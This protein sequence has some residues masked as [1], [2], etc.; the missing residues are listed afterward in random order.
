M[1][2]AKANQHNV[3]VHK[4]SIT[5]ADGESIGQFTSKL[6]DAGRNYI[7]SKLNLPKDSSVYP[8]E[9]F[10]KSIVFDV[11]QYGPN[12]KEGDRARFYAAAY[13][14]KDS[15][16]FEFSTLTEVERVTSYQAKQTATVMKASDKAP[17]W[18][19][20]AVAKAAFWSGVI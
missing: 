3:V 13:A 2:Q 10:S 19:E 7:A 15:G 20:V 18:V 8:V 17:G 1:S 14:R 11:Y 4:A 5:L 12:V 16:D 9:I 6:R